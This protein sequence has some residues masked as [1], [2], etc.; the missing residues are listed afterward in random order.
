MPALAGER[1]SGRQEVG[2]GDVTTRCVTAA[3]NDEEVVHA[4]IVSSVRIPLK[5]CFTDGTILRD[6]PWQHVFRPTESGNSDLGVPRRARSAG[7][8]LRM[9]RQALFSVESRPKPF[10]LASRP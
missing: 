8:R 5:A 2:L 1:V 4:A 7:S 3:G 10:V 6:E 9:A